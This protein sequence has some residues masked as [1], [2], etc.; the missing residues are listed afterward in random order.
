MSK[1]AAA[2]G[3]LSMLAAGGVANAAAVVDA[4][5]L[6]L[7][8][9]PLHTMSGFGASSLIIPETNTRRTTPGLQTWTVGTTGR[10]DRIELY[11]STSSSH[12]L[13]GITFTEEDFVV[14]LT[15][16]GGSLLTDPDAPALGSVTRMSSELSGTAGVRAFD[17]SAFGINAQAGDVLTWRMA[18]EA[19]PEV[20]YCTNIW[21]NYSDFF[22]EGTTNGYAGGALL[23][24]D[25]GGAYFD[26]GYDANFRTWMSAVPE[27]A[28]WAMMI[29]GFGAAGSMVRTSRR[30]SAFSVA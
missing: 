1:L 24:K 21:S 11:T 4:D 3:A 23:F 6:L 5:N 16:F 27:P 14:T 29:I 20:F 17:F 10:L 15:V 2:F 9:H 25:S 26:G 19:C 22:D 18:V 8:S 7:P 13:D 12:S 30:R 28:T